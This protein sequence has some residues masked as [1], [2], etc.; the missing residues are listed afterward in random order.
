MKNVA[1]N[2]P[3]LTLFATDASVSFRPCAPHAFLA[4]AGIRF[5]REMM[6]VV[7]MLKMLG[8]M[9]GFGGH[10]RNWN[11]GTRFCSRSHSVLLIL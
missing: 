11:R 1:G 9:R 8:T 10:A 3:R 2:V 6:A 4:C 7:L 5:V